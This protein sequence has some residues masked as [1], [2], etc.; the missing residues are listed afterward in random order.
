MALA[1]YQCLKLHQ[2]GHYPETRMNRRAWT[3][4]LIL[5]AIW[6]ASYLFIKIGVRDLSPAIVAWLRVALAAAVLVPLAASRG[7]LRL[8]PGS[9][10]AL[11]VLAAT[12]VAVPF[13]LIGVG[14][15]EVSSSMAGILVASTPLFIAL[16]AL[17]LDH[18]ERSEGTRMWGVLAGFAGVSIL[19]GVDLGGSQ[20]ELLGGIAIVVAGLGYAIGAFINKRR[21]TGPDPIGIAAWVMV[22]STGLLAPFALATLPD[23]APGLGPLASVAALGVVGTG[24]AFAIFFSLLAAVGPARTMIVTY[25]VPAFA[26]AYG[27]LLLGEEIS[28]ASVGGLALI[29]GGSYLAAQ[30]GGDAVALAP[31]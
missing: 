7:G 17:R 3:M 12:Q 11:I 5:G 8:P 13:V 9:A 1:A 29:V 28:V 20:A 19:L 31:E 14:E 21:F 24:I 15:K 16:L 22:V 18:E 26:V 30:G 27:V 4:L 2:D 6:G 25:L 23:A 10:V